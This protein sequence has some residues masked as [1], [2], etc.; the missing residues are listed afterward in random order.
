MPTQQVPKLVSETTES[1]PPGTPKGANAGKA[2]FGV[3]ISWE[4][5]FKTIIFAFIIWSIYNLTLL[6]KVHTD[7]YF[8]DR[9]RLYPIT[10]FGWS[11]LSCALFALYRYALDRFGSP[12]LKLRVNPERFPKEEDREEKGRKFAKWIGSIIYY[13]F[14]TFLCFFLF[15]KEFFFPTILGG[16]GECSLIFH[17]YPNFPEV[18]YVTFF[19]MM[20]FGVHLYTLLDHIFVRYKEPK[21][22][23]LFLHHGMAVF[24]I[25]FSYLTN[26]AFVGIMVLFVHDP[27]DIMLDL[28][29][30]LNDWSPRYKKVI[31]ITYVTFVLTWMYLRLT[32]FPACLIRYTFNFCVYE[33]IDPELRSLICYLCM[34]LMALVGL[35]LYWFGF[36]VQ[37][38]RRQLRGKGEVNIYDNKKKG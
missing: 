21:F 20:Q 36:I 8:T 31:D 9:I 18:P 6:Y 13:S 28:N 1:S 32:A 27:G 16:E 33:K 34:M 10:D 2:L 29:R 5:F 24:L 35:H 26:C 22:W 38:L 37:I 19:Y 25:F 12:L 11:L 7:P 30:V 17:G 15:R 23:E 3:I 4:Y 14:S